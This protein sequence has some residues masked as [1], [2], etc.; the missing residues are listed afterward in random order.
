MQ[1]HLVD[2]TFELFRAYHGAPSARAPDGREIGAVRG[3]AR[4]LLALLRTPGV[5]HAAVAFDTVIESFRNQ[6]F[7]GYKTGDGIE[8]ELLAQFGLAEAMASAL[9]LVVWPMVEFEADDA[10]ASF[11][12]RAEREAAVEQVVLCYPDKDLLQCVRGDRVVLHDRLRRRTI[13][14]AG[15]V[16]K[17]GVAPASVPDYLALVGD[18]ADGIPGVP[19]WGARSAAAALARYHHLDAIPAHESEWD[20]AVRGAAALAASLRQHREDALLYRTLAT[21]R[22]DVPLAEDLAALCWQGARRAELTRLCDELGD[23]D[24]LDRVPRWRDDGPP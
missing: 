8:P 21:L 6:L 13:D 17:L 24:L 7:A 2:G 11:A 16:S 18:S 23:A 14:E 19:R 22:R 9:G 15:V 12:A 4:S 10:L 5:S 20:F 1:V 3:L